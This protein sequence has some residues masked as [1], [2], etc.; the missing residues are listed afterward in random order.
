MPGGNAFLVLLDVHV[1]V[2]FFIAMIYI[3]FKILFLFFLTMHLLFRAR[4]SHNLK[5]KDTGKLNQIKIM[6]LTS[7]VAALSFTSVLVL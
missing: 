3:F 7:L 1:S 2:V 4:L 5:S 6:S